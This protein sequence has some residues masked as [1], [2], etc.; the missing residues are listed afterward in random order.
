MCDAK[1][2]WLNKE[3]EKE[4]S[5]YKEKDMNQR[6]VSSVTSLVALSFFLRLPIQCFH[7]VRKG[8]GET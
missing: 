6:C 4:R 1:S 7:H 5:L 2:S 3:M 8:K